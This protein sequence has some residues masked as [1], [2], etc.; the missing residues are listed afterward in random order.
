[1]FEQGNT[2]PAE[3]TRS[4]GTSVRTLYNW[5]DTYDESG[6]AGLEDSPKSGR[7]RFVSTYK[8]QRVVEK[9]RSRGIVTREHAT[10]N[11][12]V[13]QTSPARPSLAAAR[14]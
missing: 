10:I 12:K 6:M 3:I 13:P 4:L 11:A 14:A 5:R 8:I 7:P 2:P 1:M 9:I